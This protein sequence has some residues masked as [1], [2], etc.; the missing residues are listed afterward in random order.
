[1]GRSIASLTLAGVALLASS[2]GAQAVL[3]ADQ[4][5]RMALERNSQI[6]GANAGVLSARG[7]LYSAYSRLLPSLSADYVRSVSRSD[8]A[9]GQSLFGSVVTPSTTTDR[10]SYT[11][12][13][14]L[15]ATLPVL[16]LSSIVGF[17]SAR[18]GLMASQLA[19]Q[20]TRADVALAARQ[21][22]YQVVQAVKLVD[23]SVNAL[24][25]ARDSERRVRALFEVG[26]VS[27]N[28]VLQAQVQTAQSQLDSIGAR[29]SL[30]VQ[31]DLLASFI[32]VE[33][34]KLGEVDTVLTFS[35]REFEEAALLAEAQD[36]RPDLQAAATQLRSAKAGLLSAR[37]ARLPYVTVSGG[38]SVNPFGSFK[39]KSYGTFEIKNDAGD[40][41]GH[42]TDP[43]QSG[44]NK[45]ERAYSASIALNLDL[46]DGLATD[47]RVATARALLLRDQDAYDVLRRNLS[48]EVHEAVM[49]YQ[50]SVASEQLAESA[51]AAATESMKLTQQKYNVGSA[52]ILDL[53]T[54][55]VQLE[56]AQGQ[57]VNALAGIRVAEARIDRVRGHGE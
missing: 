47:A 18:A 12:T 21:Q 22:F 32:G 17:S 11:T 31:R 1:M 40:V 3:T 52:T 15:S 51:V 41:I 4:A 25:V 45:T 5:A 6:V 36:H 10:E 49:T 53:I 24:K 57:L 33:E 39:Q 2:V 9:S 46:F 44:R 56:R 37:L 20:A 54:A 27:R 30:L 42:V 14:S 43:V 38:A 23:V 13:P 16:N 55:Q 7:G 8:R 19:R 28:D 50:Q 29:Q 35:P 34:S 48:G 26:S